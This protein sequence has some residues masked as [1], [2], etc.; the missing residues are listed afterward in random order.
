MTTVSIV[1]TMRLA[2]G[3]IRATF[4]ERVAAAL[5]CLACAGI[6]GLAAWLH[7]AGTGHGTHTQLGLPACP[8]PASVG[9][10]CPTCGM[11][12]SFAFAAH[13][14][15]GRSFTTQPFG[16]VLALLTA[17]AF[18]A[19]LHIAATGSPAGRMYARLMRPRALWVLTGLALAAW[20]YK[21]ATWS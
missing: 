13:G 21:W 16:F 15:F 7:P 20:G 5:V 2:D 10:P 11:T 18:W 8:W 1:P 6:I 14:Q 19:G 9:G 3:P 4:G 17:A 12:T